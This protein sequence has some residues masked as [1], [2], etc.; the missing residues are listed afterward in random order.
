MVYS[1]KIEV[2]AVGGGGKGD[3]DVGALEG[4]EE[5]GDA[6]EGLA[7][8]E[9]LRLQGGLGG[10]EG[11]AGDGELGPGVEDFGGLRG[12]SVLFGEGDGA[13]R[14]MGKTYLWA[15]AA[16]QLSLYTPG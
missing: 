13:G 8:G 1:L 5:E 16:L 12:L 10:S 6:G 7:E 2:A 9:V 3:G 11:G 14:W 4:F 15:G